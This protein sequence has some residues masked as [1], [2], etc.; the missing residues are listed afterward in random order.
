MGRLLLWTAACG[1][2]DPGI[3]WTASSCV[4]NLAAI[5]HLVRVIRAAVKMERNVNFS[6][7]MRPPQALFFEV[8]AENDRKLGKQFDCPS[9]IWRMIAELSNVEFPRNGGTASS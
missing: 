4:A 7:R 5:D 3:A 8:T 6:K 1:R 9:S 2:T